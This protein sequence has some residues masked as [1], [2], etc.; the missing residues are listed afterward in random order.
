[1]SADKLAGIDTVLADD[2]SLNVRLDDG[3]VLQPLRVILD[4]RLRMTPDVKLLGLPGDTVVLTGSTDAG[5]RDALVDALVRPCRI[6]IAPHVQPEHT[7]QVPLAEDNDVIDTF[8]STSAEKSFAHCIH[9]RGAGS[10]LKHFD[11]GVL[12]HRF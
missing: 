1:M 5:K 3:E 9:P 10:D 4:S 6:E 7:P 8:S 12:V 2:P 11:A